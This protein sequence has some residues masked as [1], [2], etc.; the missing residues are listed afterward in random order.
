MAAQVEN[1]GLWPLV[2]LT[3]RYHPARDELPRLGGD[4]AALA[5]ATWR[6]ALFG[7]LLGAL[8]HRLRTIRPPDGRARAGRAG[9]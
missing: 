6:H 8:E 2:A 3:D 9:A 5:Q 1:F 7:V 4:R